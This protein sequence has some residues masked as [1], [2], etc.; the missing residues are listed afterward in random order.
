MLKLKRFHLFEFCDQPWVKGWMREG[1]M[2]CLS[3]MYWSSRPYHALAP[4]IIKQTTEFQIIDLAT[5]GGEAIEFLLKYLEKNHADASLQIVGTDLFPDQ[6]SLEI[7]KQKYP[8]FDYRT[9]SVDA[10][11]PPDGESV[12]YTMF[13]AFH[14]FREKDAVR[15]IRSCLSKGQSFTIFELTARYNLLNYIWLFIGLFAFMFVPFF[16]KKWRWQKFVF[17]ILITIIPLMCV[18]DGF[19]S[20]LRTYTKGELEDLVQK[21]FPDKIVRMDYREQRFNLLFKSYMCRLHV[22]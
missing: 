21:A 10:F 3:F 16:A 5:G 19:V 1:F 6:T 17:S 12:A 4:Q 9:E 20:N 2:D 8:H 14:H 13:G 18:F 11:D 15:L 22:K 7:V